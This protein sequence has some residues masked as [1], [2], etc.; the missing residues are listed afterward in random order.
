MFFFFPKAN[1]FSLVQACCHA[2]SRHWDPFK[3]HIGDVPASTQETSAFVNARTDW[4]ETPEGHIFKAGLPGLRNEEVKVEV[5][6]VESCKSV[7]RGA[8]RRKGMKRGIELRGEAACF[9]IGS[10][11]LRK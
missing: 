6:K 8:D 5:K 3:G 11:C 7:E 1:S 2:F 9:Y 10:G 4:K